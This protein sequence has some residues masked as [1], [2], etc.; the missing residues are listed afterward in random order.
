MAK[1]DRLLAQMTKEVAALVLMD[2]YRQSMALSNAEH[3]SVALLDEHAR[4]MRALERA[5]KLDRAVEFLPDDET[6]DQ[7]RAD[8]K[9]LVRPEMAVLL[10]YAK[11]TLDEELVTGDVLD[12]PYLVRGV[13]RYFPTPLRKQFADII[14][15]HRLRR[16]ITSTY[17][18]NS[19]VNRTGPSFINE[20]RERT[21]APVSDIARAYLVCRQVYRMAELWSGVEALDNSVPA[22][23]QTIMHLAVL[24]LIKRGTLWFLRNGPRPLAID[25]AVTAF[26]PG[27]C[28]LRDNLGRIMSAGLRQSVEAQAADFVAHKVPAALARR[29]ASLDVLAPACDI[30]RISRSE[31]HDPCSVAEIY[32]ALGAEFGFDWLRGAAKTLADGNE[33]QKMAVAAIFDDL[34]AHQTDLTV[35][36][37]DAA[38]DTRLAT[39][40]IEVWAAAH[41][42]AVSRLAALVA[43]LRTA[44]NLDL[45]MLAVANREVRS[46]VAA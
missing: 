14:P 27:V 20:M 22:E 32:Y 3:Q 4:F 1:R 19:L 16:E 40:V 43:D 34:Y 33:W 31:K 11:M 6:L 25:A 18:T 30:V 44:A 28:A 5:G 23:V 7:R 8:R 15:G 35:K 37:L 39:V 45:A 10:A 42:H 36:V 46:L 9:G 41:Q 17:V 26:E 21:G 13:D 38:G 2:N 29:V 12:D 24:Q